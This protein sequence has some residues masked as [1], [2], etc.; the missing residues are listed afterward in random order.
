MTPPSASRPLAPR[1]LAAV[2][3]AATVGAATWMRVRS[4]EGH[5]EWT[6]R[7]E[8][9]LPTE[10]MFVMEIVARG[11]PVEG[12]S[13]VAGRGE[14]VLPEYLQIE[15]LQAGHGTQ[16]IPVY[17]RKLEGRPEMDPAE[18]RLRQKG[19]RAREYLI[20]LDPPQSR[21]PSGEEPR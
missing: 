3:L 9:S 13:A 11:G 12:I 6:V 17:V 16:P 18:I 21:R 4:F 1:L 2:V 15:R 14:A 10:E 19:P 5:L 7:H 8:H 20:T